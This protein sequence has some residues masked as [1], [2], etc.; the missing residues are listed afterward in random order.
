M[1][2]VIMA[3]GRGTRI[4]SVKADVPKPMIP[5][6]GKPILE[7]QLLCLKEQGY[8]KVT[9]CVGYLGH[10]I[11][12]YFGDG[13]RLGIEISDIEEKEPLGTAGALYFLKGKVHEDILLLNGDIIFDVDIHR[14]QQFHQA[15]GQWATLFTH[16][17]SHP[18]DSG[19]LETDG[20]HLVTRWM[21]KEDAR[22][23]YSNRVNAGLHILAP[24]VL[25][26]IPELK[27]TDLDRDLLRPLVSQ[28]RVIAYDSP[29]YVK[30]MGTPD[31]YYAVEEDVR[32]GRVHARNL[33]NKQRA[34][35]FDRDGTINRYVG[36][37]RSMDEFELIPDTVEKIRWANNNGYLAIVVT[38][39]PVIAR[40][41]VTWDELS[42]IHKKMETLLG[43]KGVY[44]D[45]IFICP[46]HPDKGF[47]G[48][49]AAYK[50]NCDCRK[51]KPGLLLQ[52]AAKYNIDLSESF[53][54][55]DSDND[56]KAAEAAGCKAYIDVK[57]PWPVAEAPKTE[58]AR[59]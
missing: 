52:A 4:A 58:V 6:C 54:V 30:D 56:R 17:N 42:L 48:E 41:E 34:V 46:H 57:D 53:M 2:I 47:E 49:V 15:H 28:R 29:E 16:P 27:K 50:V 25:D 32:S 38:N 13:E 44:V 18:Y 35:F 23:W 7:H 8:R 19:V 21:T 40:G 22:T 9:L 10:V 14:F 11:Q 39:Q 1:V 43:E 33:L 26:M 20:Q 36:F 37:L 5:I 3:G 24:Q 31:R 45:D 59:S 12:E 51:P 55:G